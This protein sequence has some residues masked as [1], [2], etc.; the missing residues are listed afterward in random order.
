MQKR[1]LHAQEAAGNTTWIDEQEAF[2]FQVGCYLETS[3]EKWAYFLELKGGWSFFFFFPSLGK[4]Q[5]PLLLGRFCRV[6]PVPPAQ[7]V[8][9]PHGPPSRRAVRR[10]HGAV[11]VV[12]LAPS[13]LRWI[14][15]LVTFNPQF[16]WRLNRLVLFHG[17]LSLFL[18]FS[19]DNLC[20]PQPLNCLSFPER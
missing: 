3:Q 6:C 10:R 20:A 11:L 7:R 19:S 5:V 2:A 8:G 18:F 13:R 16:G 12:L 4:C 1:Y 17:S 9:A 15:L 14:G